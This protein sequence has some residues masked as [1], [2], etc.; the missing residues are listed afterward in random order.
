MKKITLWLFALFASLQMNA[1]VNAYSFSQT[2]GTYTEI[3]G[4]TVL[5]TGT[6][7][8]TSYPAIPI[9]FNFIFGGTSYTD[10]SINANGMIALGTTISYSYTPLSD[11]FSSNNAIA[12]LG[13]DLQGNAAGE[14]SYLL[15]GSAPNQ[16]LTVQWKNYRAYNTTGDNYNFQVKLY[17]TT[18]NIDVVY[19]AFTKNATAQTNQVGLRGASTAVFN[20]RSTATNWSATTTG[21]LNT[22]TCTLNTTIIP[23]SGL[24][25]TWAPPSCAAPGGL[26]ATSITSTSA[27]IGWNAAIPAPTGYEY[28]VS[29]LNTTPAGSG[30]ATTN[31]TESIGS[32]LPQTTYYVFVRSNCGGSFSSW[33]SFSF[34][35]ACAP[36]TTYPSLEPFATFLPNQCWSQGID[37][38]LTSGPASTGTT[39]NWYVDGL[40]NVGTTGAVNYNLY[41]SGG[42]DWVISPQ[43]AIPTTGYELKLIA[44]ITNYGATTSPTNWDAGDTVEILVSTTGMTNWIPLYT[45]DVSNYSSVLPAGSLNVLDLDAYS[46]Q[47]VRFA[48]RAFEGAA[49]RDIDFSFDDF[50]VRLSPTCP[51][52]TGLTVGNITATTADFSW[53]DLSG[54]GAVGYEYAITTSATP[55]ASGTATALTYYSGSSFMPQTLYYLHVRASCA[56]SIFGNWSTIS[57]TT[58]CS[59]V[60]SFVQNFDA[61]TTPAFPTC[62]TKVGPDGTTNTQTGSANSAPNTMYF[63]SFSTTSLAVVSMQPVSN[64]GA[65]TNRIKFDMRANFTVGGV[66]EFGYLTDPLDANTFV[67]LTTFTA[68]SLTY[69]TYQYSPVAGVYSDYPAFRHTGNPGNSVLIDNVIWE[70]LPSCPDQTGLTVSNVTSSGADTSWDAIAAGVE[71][72][73][74][75]S[76]TP[77]ASGTATTATFFQPTGLMPQTTYYLHVRTDCGAG[78]YGIWVT[79]PFTTACTALTTLPWTENFDSLTTGNDI[80]PTCWNYSN[81][82]SNWSIST[83]PTAYSGANSLRRTW[84]TDGWAFTPM[85]TL[86]GGTSYTF[87]YFVRTN[88]T[89]VGYD[90]T[91]GVGNSQNSA[92]M[93]TT[94]SSV[95][96]YQGPSWTLVTIEYTPT[97]SGDYSFGLHVVAPFAPNGINFDDFKLEETPACPAPISTASNIT[98][99]SA[100]LS[101]A[102]VPSATL[103]YEYVLDTFATDPAVSG[104][105]TL[106]LA[107]AATGLTQSTTYY[108]HIRSVCSVGTYSTWST[109]SFTTLAT[110]PVNDDCATAIAVTSIP[111]TNTQDATAASQSAF[112]TACADTMND[113]VWYTVVGN[114]YDIIVDINAVVGWDPQVD[115]YTG[116][117][118]AFNCVGSADVGGTSGSESITIPASIL[119]TTYYIN[120]GH[121]SGFTNSP[122]GPFTINISSPLTAIGFDKSNFVAYPN[123]VKDVLNL[124]YNSVINNVR[125]VNLLG[126]EVLNVKSNTNDVQV[127]MASLNAGAYIVTVSVENTVHSIKVIKQ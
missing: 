22:D 7:D 112:V 121:Y 42:N 103:G 26:N 2:S 90:V 41:L 8:D 56:A 84:S 126:Q 81:A 45:Y 53:S 44:A 127:N 111:Y 28:V 27:T 80:F 96:G 66:V 61:V 49:G 115:V 73:V 47:T 119:G 110:P 85:F 86:T 13:D 33:N 16:V 11:G 17:E 113:G 29:T 91:V 105:S 104:A 71:Y 57:F 97:I 117:C 69:N 109:V 98:D 48:I 74:T 46:G 107:Y 63:A 72:A 108:F 54:S 114:G 125:V 12:A 95:V 120:V 116:T 14:L 102:A 3:T 77:P 92:S 101:W 38:D 30:T 34:M 88:D 87:S 32:L 123:P 106:A 39:G 70:L 31:L 51:D 23:A 67:S 35:T 55:P 58:N 75:T 19:G 40:G 65:G 76:A 6:V 62:W 82:T 60:T 20:N 1:Q 78:N 59:T 21:A 83:A 50:E 4:G 124:S 18:N 99:V 43:Y 93:S 9:G 10:I 122:E 94:L 52:L 36:I 79:V 100:D 89:T 25:F 68:S 5:G 15:T 118:G 64:L 24:T 37:G